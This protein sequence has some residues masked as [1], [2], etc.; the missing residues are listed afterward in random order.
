MLSK[1]RELFG[2]DPAR[3]VAKGLAARMGVTPNKDGRVVGE[4]AGARCRITLEAEA[5]R[6][7]V[8]MATEERGRPWAIRFA[9]E[10]AE[11][12]FVAPCVALTPADA[13]LFEALPLQVRVHVIDVV[14]AGKG[15]IHFENGSLTLSVAPAGLAR[16]NAV[17]QAAIRLDVLAELAKVFKPR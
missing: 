6:M 4:W 7:L 9:D 1:L 10:D 12:H 3:K 11:L 17:D 8:S 15:A 13:E 14:E 16:D 5:D 2:G